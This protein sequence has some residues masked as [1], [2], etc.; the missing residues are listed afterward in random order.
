MKYIL[1]F[2]A[3][4]TLINASP[5][6]Y[7]IIID[8]PFNNALID[9]TQDYDRSISAIGFKKEYKQNNNSQEE[10][11]NAFDYLES[12]STTHGSQMHLIKLDENSG[13]IRL[14]KTSKLSQFNEAIALVKTPQ[15]GYFI[16]GYTLDGSLLFAKLN[17]NGD[18]ISKTIFGTK[19]YD[20]LNNL[21]KLSDGGVLAIGTSI[22]SRNQND[23]LFETGLGLNDIF[24]TRFSKKG[25]KLWSKKYGTAYDDRG[26]DAVEALDNS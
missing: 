14:R 8:E 26:I 10:Y 19:N 16:G 17:S 9:V 22:T 1:T 24:I 13:H 20:R 3:L 23:N 7:S 18:L 2:L 11:T 21:V 4:F 12:I 6:E 25:K 15:N 5:H